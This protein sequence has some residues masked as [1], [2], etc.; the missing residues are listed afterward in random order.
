MKYLDFTEVRAIFSQEL[1]LNLRYEVNEDIDS[2]NL[3]CARHVQASYYTWMEE[4]AVEQNS[5]CAMRILIWLNHQT[6][7]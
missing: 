2:E 7:W 3:S 4:I 6:M 5:F 1:T